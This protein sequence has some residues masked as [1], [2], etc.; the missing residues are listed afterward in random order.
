M[1]KKNGKVKEPTPGSTIAFKTIFIILFIVLI[2]LGVLT[3][4]PIAYNATLG[5]EGFKNGMST[6]V[7]NVGNKLNSWYG[8]SNTSIGSDTYRNGLIVSLGLLTVLITTIYFVLK[9]FSL[10]GSVK[11]K[12]KR[13]IGLRRFF[14]A[15]LA[16]IDIC[17][18]ATLVLVPFSGRLSKFGEL[19]AKYYSTC[20]GK[21][22]DLL[23]GVKFFTLFG[24]IDVTD[25]AGVNLVGAFWI[26]VLYILI[27]I[28]LMMLI[29]LPNKKPKEKKE[30]KPAE[31]LPEEKV[32]EEKPL[33]AAEPVAK[34]EEKTEEECLVDAIKGAKVPPREKKK[35]ITRREL[36]I[37]NTLEPFGLSSIQELPGMYKE[38]P[39][40]II[41]SLEPKELKKTDLP[42]ETKEEAE[43]VD[44]LPG[45]D[46]WNASPWQDE[47]TPVK[48][49]V[50]EPIPPVK[51]EALMEDMTVEAS[52]VEEK[53]EV[54]EEKEPAP[55]EE[56]I[57]EPKVEEVVEEKP[58]EI[59]EEKPEVVE[60]VKEEVV[61]EVKEE[62][63]EEVK[64]EP[65]VEEIVEEEP[66][67][68]V[69]ETKPVD[70]DNSWVLPEYDEEAE[71]RKAEEARRLA[72]E[73]AAKKAAE[74]E[75]RRLAEEEAAKKAAEE[76]ARRLAE[77][78]A[79][80]KAAEEEARRLAEEE[81]AKKAA[82]EEARRLAEEEAAKKAAEEEARR[83]AEEEA[84]KK[85]AEE[86]EARRLA[87]EEAAKKA[88]E[89]EEAR[90]LAEEEAAKKVAEEEEAR[91]LAEEEAAKK[92]AEEAKNKPNIKVVKLNPV[93]KPTEP[94]NKPKVAPIVPIKQE[95]A[96]EVVEEEKKLEKISGPMHK[97][98]KTD[99]PKDIKPVT[100]R[101]V[102][103]ELS[104]YRIKTYNG[105]LTSEQAFLKGVTKVQPTAQPIFV[106][107][108]ESSYK[109]KR[110]EEEI[111]KNGYQ[112]INVVKNTN[113]LKPVKPINPSAVDNGEIKE[114]KPV[115]PIAPVKPIEKP[116]EKSVVERKYDIVKP[117]AALNVKKPQPNTNKPKPTLIK[118][119][120]TV[121]VDN[122]K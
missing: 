53:Q 75:A 25:A 70:I 47:V 66:A 43:P 121:K 106:D 15:L 61:E 56:V 67:Y 33:V 88:A 98:N 48:E 7:T 62:V 82:E 54:F 46:E 92:A 39:N 37:L 110:R 74:E 76:E 17:V 83:L 119:I 78:E 20:I 24:K 3:F 1:S 81:A 93:H 118:P 69:L 13:K 12:H 40:E 77:E 64:E 57:E 68:K 2:A 6:F 49:K 111:R 101:K 73:E 60:E 107:K 116:V 117:V 84:A 59:I 114:N 34:K 16:I 58:V 102:K 120:K 27:N 50:I 91:R 55:V 105:D 95:T 51:E 14:L 109:K 52:E 99:A 72:E 85:A 65:K 44:V 71:K 87:E 42:D 21:F 30:E 10:M 94:A 100:A 112:N 9:C 35:P 63:I 18:L 90:R 103:F 23:K 45:I 96:P 4:L 28:I 113:D 5:V 122:K 104:K 80:K 36:A 97:V 108:N 38:D 11:R 79:A 89:E 32:V 41:E 29:T 8:F 31:A 26:F 86:E 19:L 22:G 115:K